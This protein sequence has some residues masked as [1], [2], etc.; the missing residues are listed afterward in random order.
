MFDPDDA[1]A[2]QTP[3]DNG[4]VGTPTS[5]RKFLSMMLASAGGAM[6]SGC[7]GGGGGTQA[8]GSVGKATS[9]PSPASQAVVSVPETVASP[10]SL[11]YG[12]NGHMA[13]G[14]GI[15]KSMSPADQLA[16][17]KDLGVTNYRCDIAGSVMSQ[18][19]ADALNGP[20]AGSGVSILPV[21]NPFSAGWD[22]ASSE[23]AAYTLGYDLGVNC[24]RPLK[25]LVTHI[26]CGNELDVPLKIG[27]DG[28]LSSDWNPAYWPSFRGALRGM[29]DG[30]KSIDPSI[31]CGVN[32]GIPM[33]YRALQMLWN[34]IS[35]DGS[36]A[37][38]SGAAALRWDFTTYHWYKSSGDI[39]CGGRYNA[40]VDVLQV[41]KDSFDVP[42]WLTEWGWAGSGDTQQSAADY[43]T[44]ALRQYRSI[45]D[46]YNIESVM[47]YCLIDPDYGLVQMDGT[48]KNAAYAAFRNFVAANPV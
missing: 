9:D 14:N 6:L 41:L 48:S 31:K 29:L 19:L 25:G 18:V 43:V 40:C 8:V 23:S 37:G 44:K 30:V 3:A 24:A 21:L 4:R 33:A 45:K 11:F 27:G 10:S 47:M 16:I 20:F 28:S 38:V 42:I 46:K 7:G 5:R 12:M 15:Y 26:E 1:I 34:G 2:Q 17:L 35:P 22:C 13:Y 32:V 39:Q 36:A